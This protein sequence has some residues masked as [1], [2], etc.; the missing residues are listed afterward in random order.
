[1]DD[2]LDVTRIASGK[3]A[4]RRAEVDVAAIVARTAED[5]RS[6]FADR[7]IALEVQAP[8][9]PLR[10]AAD[11]T[12]VAQVVGNL[13]Q[14]AAKFTPAGGR[15]EVR[16]RRAGDRVE[17]SVRDSGVGIDPAVRDRVFEPF[18]QGDRTLARSG[19]G[20]GLGLALV[21]GLAELHGGGVTVESEGAGRG[22]EFRFWLP[23][24]AEARPPAP[25]P[26]AGATAA[27]RRRVLVV[28]DNRDAAESLAELVEA[29]GHEVEIA[30]DGP[31]ALARA[32]ATRHDV[33]L[34]DIG[35]PGMSGYDVA[36]ALREDPGAGFG[37][38]V[39]VSGYAQPDDQRRAVEAGFDQHVAKPPDP[40]ELERLLS[41]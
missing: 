6:L 1:V 7:G 34:C 24:G 36:R 11:P 21:K 15:V 25:E 28:D 23:A 38:L 37:Q 12:R 33:V 22:S 39:A 26:G 32:R 18:V 19:G 16:A 41:R 40:S 27:G 17:V 14:N 13:L 2:L 10:A 35:L 3:I 20:L 29:F 5:H 9:A 8:E 30:H 4:L 31:T